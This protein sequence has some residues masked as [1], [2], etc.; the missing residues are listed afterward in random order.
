M[1]RELRH[2]PVTGIRPNPQQPRQQFDAA[3]LQELANSM[4]AEGLIQPIEVEA[5]GDGYILH[6]G[7]R[8]LRAARLLEWKTIEALVVAPLD[9]RDR[10][11][12]ALIENIQRQDM[13]PTETAAAYRALLDDGLSRI[14][15]AHQTGRALETITAYL[16][17]L[18]LPASVQEKVNEG[19]FPVDR[20][21][22]AALLAI[23]DESDRERL[24]LRMAVPGQTI[25]GILQAVETYKDIKSPRQA[26]SSREGRA[27]CGKP[28]DGVVN[29]TRVVW[30]GCPRPEGDVY[31][32]A[33]KS[34]ARCVLA[35]D[36]PTLACNE[37]QLVFF[38]RLYAQSQGVRI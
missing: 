24:A 2:I 15:I 12:R 28:R 34:C 37:C 20:R 38:V 18:D 36:R 33:E 1:E 27:D 26:P 14:E 4:R 17:L 29:V 32:L 8:R 19:L 25:A 11:R 35:G 31:E 7:E 23:A 21:V 6:H 10:R 9:E 30:R 13:L 5:D 3:A 16:R 22:S